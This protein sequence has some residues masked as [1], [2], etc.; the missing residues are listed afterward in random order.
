MQVGGHI[1]CGRQL[2]DANKGNTDNNDVFTAVLQNHAPPLVSCTT[3]RRMHAH[4]SITALLGAQL[5]SPWPGF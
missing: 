2:K 5:L 4:H 3:K 1:A